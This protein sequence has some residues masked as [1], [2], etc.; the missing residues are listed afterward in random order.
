MIGRL[1]GK[2]SYK[3]ERFI[4]LNV[5][6]VGYKVFITLDILQKT[7]EG[8][9]A[10]F[11]TYLAVRE[12]ALD[13]YG[14]V[15]RESLDFFEMLLDVPGIGPKSA[16]TVL[17]TAGIE[18]L[19]SAISSSDHNYLTKLSGIGRRTAEKIVLEL[20]DKMGITTESGNT[21][22]KDE[23]D[24]IDAL[25][26]LGYREREARDALKKVPKETVGT[27]QKIKEALKILGR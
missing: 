3:D 21:T 15:D 7:K 8:D 14:F 5:A 22:M 17:S 4:I 12:N 25:K 11:W 24:A 23:S 1:E 27:N 26:S 20:K 19:K 9:A 13:L 10:S 2:I 6:G 16:M 18:T